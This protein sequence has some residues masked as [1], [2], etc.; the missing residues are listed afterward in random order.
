MYTCNVYIYAFGEVDPNDEDLQTAM[1][2]ASSPHTDYEPSKYFSTLG[3]VQP[4]HISICTC[5]YLC[6]FI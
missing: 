6:I 2:Q 3:K 1:I 4:E 5:I